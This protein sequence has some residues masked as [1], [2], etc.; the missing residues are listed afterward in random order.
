MLEGKPGVVWNHWPTH[1]PMSRG[2]ISQA[3]PF[4]LKSWVEPGNEVKLDPFPLS[5]FP[6]WVLFARGK[7]L[8]TL[9]NELL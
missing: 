9:A 6:F 3:L 2:F 7:G 8:A 5:Y 1:A 4:F